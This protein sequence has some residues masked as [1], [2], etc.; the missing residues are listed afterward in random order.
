MSYWEPDDPPELPEGC[1]SEDV[2]EEIRELLKYVNF[3]T[4]PG[5]KSDAALILINEHINPPKVGAV[6]D[7]H[8]TWAK[9]LLKDIL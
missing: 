2:V 1:I 4:R 8:V 5:N 3:D 9:H 6:E 7:P